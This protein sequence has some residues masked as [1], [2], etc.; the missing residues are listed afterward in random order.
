MVDRETAQLFSG[1]FA[2]TAAMRE[3]MVQFIAAQA[4][5]SGD[6]D[7][8]CR[9]LSESV[10]QPEVPSDIQAMTIDR[11]DAIIAQ[12]RRISIPATDKR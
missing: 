4:R 1:I 5:R 2:E 9:E 10:Q 6:A 12:I 11:I 7:G 3:V 8:F